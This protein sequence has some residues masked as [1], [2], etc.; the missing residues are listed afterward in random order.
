MLAVHPVPGYKVAK[1]A[2]NALTVQWAYALADEGFVV[3]CLNPGVS[4]LVFTIFIG[5]N[6][7]AK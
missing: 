4:V 6:V 2:L 3:V 1:A 7:N 5:P